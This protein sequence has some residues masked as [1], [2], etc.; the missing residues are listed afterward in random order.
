MNFSFEFFP[1]K[2][3]QAEANLWASIKDL[4]PLA[5]RFVSVTYGAGGTT[6][7]RTHDCVRRIVEDTQLKPAAHLTCVSADRHEVDAVIED[8]K[9]AGVRHIVALRG[10]M[11][12]FAPY[13]PNPNGYQS[14]V[15]LVKAIS[16]RGG[17]EV[18]V[19]AYPE[20]HPE[21]PGLAHDIDLLKA[22]QDAGA[23]RAITQFAFDTSAYIRFRDAMAKE[24]LSI[25]LCPAI[26]PT[27]N[28]VGAARMAEKCGTAVP[29]ALRSR[30]EGLE[31]DLDARR[32]VGEAF[33]LEQC[34]ILRSEGFDHIHFYTLNQA[35]LT[36]HVCRSLQKEGTR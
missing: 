2:S 32:D 25:E 22:K 34:E 15:E 18:S 6:R 28:F 17:F 13:Q 9:R 26:M 8:Y 29:D 4:A 30:F 19:S 10:D 31:D 14:T 16:D 35:G 20:G 27:T 24:N 3:D 11:P 33:A 12:D 1:P 21:S 7:T 5:P 23:T 36:R